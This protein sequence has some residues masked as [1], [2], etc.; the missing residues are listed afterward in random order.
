MNTSHR[1]VRRAVA[2]VVGAGGVLLGVAAPAF[3]D[4]PPGC[5]TA[6]MTAVMTGVSA[7]MTTYL[8]THP[9]VN[10]FFS[11]LHGQSKA[12]ARSQTNA[13]LQAHPQV[14]AEIDE[15]RAPSID[16]RNR[17]NIPANAVIYG[18]L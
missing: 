4:P 12:D 18:V 17:C 3:A 15:I 7:S 5:T 9:D 13:Y 14:R 8:F 10:A 1:L 16:L 11:G 6:D 2:L